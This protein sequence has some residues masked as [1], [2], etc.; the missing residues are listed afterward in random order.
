MS[1]FA[2]ELTI[3]FTWG[4]YAAG[5]VVVGLKKR[6]TPIRYLAMIVFGFTTFKVFAVDLS[7]LDR[8]YRVLSTIALGVT[9]L[10]TSYLYQKQLDPDS[11]VVR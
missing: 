5:L 10:A 4:V 2:Q 9:L 8:I 3:S 1:R 6:Y 11:P 7:E